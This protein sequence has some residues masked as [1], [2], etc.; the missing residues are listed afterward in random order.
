M[1]IGRLKEISDAKKMRIIE[2]LKIFFQGPKE[3]IFAL[4][5]GSMVDPVVPQKYGD[6][7]SAVFLKQEEI[8]FPEYL[9]ESK[10]EVQ[11]SK[12][13]RDRGLEFAYSG[14][15]MGSSIN[16]HMSPFNG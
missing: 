15:K 16:G 5:Y 4:L 9:L 13:L 2:G 10:M 6:I 11:V 12:L 1:A 7:D 3:V 8:K 14:I